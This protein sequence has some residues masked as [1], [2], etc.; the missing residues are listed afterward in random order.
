MQYQQ[1][2]F[3]GLLHANPVFKHLTP[4][5]LDEIA[6]I[7]ELKHYAG[8]ELVFSEN[9]EAK[10]LFLIK[11]GSF[12]LSLRNSDHKE[13]G[14]GQL[15][16]EIAIINA[17]LRTGTVRANEPSS[18][19][20]ICGTRLFNSECV[21]PATA[22]KVVR[23]LAEKITNYLRSREQTSTLQL[24]QEGESEHVEF[25]SSL[26]WNMHTRRKDH[27]IEHAVLKT[28]CA[29]MNAEGGT[30]LVGVN[31]EGQILGLKND[32]FLNEDKMMLHLTKLVSD[33]INPLHNQFLDMQVETIKGKQV[34]R[35]ECEAA[36]APAYLTNGHDEI[37]YVRTGPAST[38]LPVS[39][40]YDYISM[41]F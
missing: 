24:I 39:K 19:L 35:I 3:T 23:A 37:F 10:F 9:Q 41:R 20:T 36:T 38:N 12:V 28:V 17:R 13:F 26:R 21:S 27:S 1:D 31:D 34:L 25:K 33:R 40:I 15:F 18:A 30:L 32:Q 8:D 2:S 5:E 11:T 29:F 6:G 22:L 4:A 14:P 16:G 7:T